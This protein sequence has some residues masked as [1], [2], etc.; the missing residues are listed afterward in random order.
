MD[1]RLPAHLE[2]AAIRRIAESHGGFATVLSNG[3]RDA[4]T[5]AIVISCPDGRAWLLE[6]MP[7]ADGNRIFVQTASQDSENPKEFYEAIRRRSERDPDLWVLEV[8]IANPER[9]VAALP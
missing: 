9:F 1:A 7:Q 4:G 8:E 3:D 5:L 2:V 6:R